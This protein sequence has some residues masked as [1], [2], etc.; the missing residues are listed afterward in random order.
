MPKIKRTAKNVAALFAGDIFNRLIGFIAVAYLARILGASNFGLISIGLA[1][2]SYFLTIS[3]NGLPILGVRK[4]IKC[5]D[6]NEIVGDFISTRF[7]FSIFVIIIIIA[8]S[9]F[10]KSS[11][12]RSIILAYSLYLFPTAFLLVWYFQAKEQMGLLVSGRAVGMIF[13]LVLILIFVKTNKHIIYVPYCWF[14][15]GLV[16]SLFFILIYV[17]KGNKIKIRFSFYRIKSLFLEAFPLGLANLIGQITLYLPPIFLG[18][19]MSPKEA[20]FYSAAAKIVFL[21]LI[22]DRVFSFSFFPAIS[23]CVTKTPE[24]LNNVFNQTLKW[25]VVVV[26]LFG[27]LGILLGKYLVLLVFGKEYLSSVLIFQTI[28]SYFM[29]TLINSAFTFTLIALKQEK[30]Y[31]FSL[32]IGSIVFFASA[33][34]LLKIFGPAGMGI[35][36]GIYQAVVLLIMNNK[37]KN[38]LDTKFLKIIVLPLIVSIVIFLP[39]M[40]IV[41]LNIIFKILVILTCMIPISR[42]IGIKREELKF[43]M[44]KVI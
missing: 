10:I 14:V 34:F 17:S 42:L 27:F 32:F 23:K 7:V 31:T 18:F 37:L 24:R 6:D 11:Q 30:V 8:I 5:K 38:F 25:I 33:W 26:I 16:T 3:S 19:V 1:F 29:L 9:F 35:G 44:N 41:D 22:L 39:L 36:L 13:Y 12:L 2:L 15:S 20:G 21:F 4:I 43:L 40:F 28:M